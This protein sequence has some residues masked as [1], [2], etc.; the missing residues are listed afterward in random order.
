MSDYPKMLY[1][2]GFG[3][4]WDGKQFEVVTVDDSSAEAVADADGFVTADKAH[5]LYQ[6]VVAETTAKSKAAPSAAGNPD[7]Q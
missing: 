3:I 1:R 4:D 2:E 7:G 6:P 5:T